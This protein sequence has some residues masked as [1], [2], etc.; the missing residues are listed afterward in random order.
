MEI[1]GDGLTLVDAR[2]AL[3]AQP[4]SVLVGTEIAEFGDGRAV[5]R[6]PKRPDLLQQNGFVH[7]GV[8]AY[9]ADNSVTFAAGTVMGAAVLTASVSV[10]Y[11][12]P[13]EGD[14]VADARVVAR[15]SRLAV[16]ECQIIADGV[17]CAVAHG[18]VRPAGG[19][20]E[21]EMGARSGG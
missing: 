4:F 7:G 18:T 10:D 9:L 20:R 21:R 1:S 8:L 14:L 13:A 5:L 11:M 17:V 19:R 2:A 12:R 16:C 15:T 3:A 6:L